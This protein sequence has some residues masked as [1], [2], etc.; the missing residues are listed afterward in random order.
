MANVQRHEE[1]NGVVVVYR[2]SQCNWES[3][4]ILNRD[5]EG[6]PDHSCPG[7]CPKCK[8]NGR[9]N[10]GVAEYFGEN[11]GASLKRIECPDCGGTGKI[12]S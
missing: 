12:R 3:V 5:D 4:P 1:P 10:P 2:C 8:G 7:D 11:G 6:E 9:V